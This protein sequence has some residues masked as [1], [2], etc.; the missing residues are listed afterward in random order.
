[1][2]RIYEIIPDPEILLSLEPEELAGFVMEFFNSLSG[3]DLVYLNKYN[4]G[5]YHTYKEYPEECWN[6]ISK[7]L[8]EAWMWLER[9]GLI[10]PLPGES[11]SRYFITRR[12]KQMKGASNEGFNQYK[13]TRIY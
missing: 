10:A 2:K 1:M 4:F 9:E 6:D 7:A 3:D 8:I 13:N 11:T 5:L 12:G